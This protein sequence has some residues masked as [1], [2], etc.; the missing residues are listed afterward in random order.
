MVTILDGALATDTPTSVML[1]HDA[2]TG[3]ST[4]IVDGKPTVLTTDPQ[5]AVALYEGVRARLR[6]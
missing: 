3:V 2:M 4:L 1:R 6:R 5:I